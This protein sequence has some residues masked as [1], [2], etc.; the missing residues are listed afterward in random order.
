MKEKCLCRSETSDR[1]FAWSA[2]WAWN[3]AAAPQTAGQ[4]RKIWLCVIAIL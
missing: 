3:Q 4:W 2:G 1:R